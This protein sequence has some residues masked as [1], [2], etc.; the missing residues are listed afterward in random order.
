MEVLIKYCMNSFDQV[1]QFTE[2]NSY[3][4]KFLF[5][6]C[7]FPIG[8][9]VMKR[10]LLAH[11]KA[12]GS[13]SIFYQINWSTWGKE[14]VQYFTNTSIASTVRQLGKGGGE[15]AGTPEDFD[16]IST[17][18]LLTYSESHLYCY[19]SSISPSASALNRSIH[20]L[21]IPKKTMSR[22]HQGSDCFCLGHLRRGGSM[23]NSAY[24]K[25]NRDDF[26]NRLLLCANVVKVLRVA[27]PPAVASFRLL[28]MPTW[29]TYRL[30][31]AAFQ[32]GGVFIRFS[33]T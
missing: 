13:R 31:F 4:F 22:W 27:P 11:L 2:I 8:Q 26:L 1:D 12:T 9:S 16:Y 28:G 32:D 18:R 14:L 7:A 24:A 6:S 21:E 5:T 19:S 25:N 33:R 15:G 23:T 20:P 17:V 29:S 30:L 3:K 10:N